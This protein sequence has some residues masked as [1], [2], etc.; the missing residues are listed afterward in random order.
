VKKYVDPYTGIL[1]GKNG[2]PHA[3]AAAKRV[4]ALVLKMQALYDRLNAAEKKVIRYV[5]DHPEE[6]VSLSVSDLADK[7][8]SSEATVVRACRSVGMKGYQDLK[9]SLIQN[10]VTP[11]QS[12]HEEIGETDSASAVLDKIFQSTIH[13][14]KYTRDVIDITAVER[15]AGL[16]SQAR[17]IAVF[18]LGNSHAIALDAQHK[19]LRLGLNVTAFADSH[20]QSISSAFLGT[21]DVVLA[22][23]HSGSSRDV[24]EA[25]SV[26]RE[27]GAKVIS[28][29]NIGTSPL[30]KVSDVSLCTASNETK[31]RIV[32]VASRHAA[33]VIIDVIYTLIAMRKGEQAV[34]GFKRVEVALENKKY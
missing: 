1:R 31:Y 22:I 11:L 21:G 9:L 8:G 24:I 2:K 30:T 33:M 13:T 20:L 6:V 26:A 7:S 10:I 19:F 27:N 16:I 18:G 28:I 5:I 4:P 12:I 23:S 32:A 17:R 34:K 15:A 25:A 3:G 14:L 29:S